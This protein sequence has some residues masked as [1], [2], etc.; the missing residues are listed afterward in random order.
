MPQPANIPVWRDHARVLIALVILRCLSRQNRKP[1]GRSRIVLS[2]FKSVLVY[3][4]VLHLPFIFLDL[5][6]D[7][8]D[9]KT[10]F[11]IIRVLFKRLEHSLP[12]G[13]QSFNFFLLN[14]QYG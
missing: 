10:K 9:L 11:N 1:D 14:I 2:A 7:D 6:V 13:F 8:L 3:F 12:S 4:V 5:I